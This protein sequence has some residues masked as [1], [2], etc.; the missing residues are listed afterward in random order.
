VSERF[1]F[2]DN[3]FIDP[4]RNLGVRKVAFVE[5]Q[6][7][8]MLVGDADSYVAME[9]KGREAIVSSSFELI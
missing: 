9:A 2:A 8:E 5:G 7:L 3:S 6:R 4:L 1:R